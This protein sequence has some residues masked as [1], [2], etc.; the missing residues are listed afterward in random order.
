MRVLI[1]LL[2]VPLSTWEHPLP[3]KHSIPLKQ[4]ELEPQEI[5]DSICK[6]LGVNPEFMRDLAQCESGWKWV[7]G[8]YGDKGYF[9]IIPS[10]FKYWS[11]KINLKGHSERN[12]IIVA[13]HYIKYLRDRYGSYYKARFAYGRGSWRHPYTWTC[14]EEAFMRKVNW[15]KYDM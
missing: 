4:L 12:N 13:T 2:L 10:T 3:E 11:K 14:M 7:T 8:S 15:R 9:Q 5:S 6:E 1:L